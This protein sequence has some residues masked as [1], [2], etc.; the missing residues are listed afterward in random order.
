[1]AIKWKKGIKS[2]LL[3]LKQRTILRRVRTNT[4]KIIKKNCFCLGEWWNLLNLASL[5]LTI[6]KT[7][8][9]A[10]LLFL[11]TWPWVNQTYMNNADNHQKKLTEPVR[12]NGI[13]N[14][15]IS[16]PPHSTLFCSQ[17]SQTNTSFSSGLLPLRLVPAVRPSSEGVSFRESWLW[18]YY[19]GLYC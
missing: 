4:K 18:F 14:L 6:L 3:I 1:M 8:P 16:K 13:K 2:H 7:L 9:M 12:E 11:L 17:L 15:L 10:K 5:S 19:D